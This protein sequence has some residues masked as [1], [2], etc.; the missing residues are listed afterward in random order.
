MRWIVLR[1]IWHQ[2]AF[3]KVASA[4]LLRFT[5]CSGVPVGKSQKVGAPVPTVRFTRQSQDSSEINEIKHQTVRTDSSSP[6]AEG[7]RL[8]PE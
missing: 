3:P 8:R 6:I 7:D 2:D 5:S 4:D 1:L